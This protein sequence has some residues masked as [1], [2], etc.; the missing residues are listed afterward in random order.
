VQLYL[1]KIQKADSTRPYALAYSFRSKITT[2]YALK[3]ARGI[4]LRHLNPP[5]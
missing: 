2:M 4:S 1:L 5:I 3:Q